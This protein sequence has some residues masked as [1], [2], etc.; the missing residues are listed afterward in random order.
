MTSCNGDRTRLPVLL[1]GSTACAVET[2]CNAVETT[3]ALRLAPVAG[4]ARPPG[5]PERHARGRGSNPGSRLCRAYE[6]GWQTCWRVCSGV[7]SRVPL[8]AAVTWVGAK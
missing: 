6:L 4:I 3:C 2:S 8:V 5:K 7:P 1:I